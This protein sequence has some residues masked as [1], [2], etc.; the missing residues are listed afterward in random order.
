MKKYLIYTKKIATSTPPSRNRVV[1]TVRAIAI[2]VVVLGHWLAA[3]IW[4]R[5]NGDIQLMN[6]LEWVNE[7]TSTV[8]RRLA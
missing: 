4:L 5:A 3:S 1:D 2:I 7:M 6:S 8:R